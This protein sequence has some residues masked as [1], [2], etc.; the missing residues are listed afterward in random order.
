MPA[1]S[2]LHGL[3]RAHAAQVLVHE[4]AHAWLWLQDFPAEMDRHAEEGLCELFAYHWLLSEEA[5]EGG[6]E[7]DARGG[8]L[9]AHSPRRRELLQR[10]R[11][12]ELNSDRTY[13]GGFRQALRAAEPRCPGQPLRL[14]TA[15]P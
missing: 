6:A 2:L 15:W 10:I 11:V 5:R 3:P 9:G 12:M 13:G 7:V 8:G 14:R 4:L 1:I